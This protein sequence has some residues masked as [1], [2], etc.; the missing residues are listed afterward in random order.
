MT[1][2]L[3]S[4]TGLVTTKK[5]KPAEKVDVKVF[6]DTYEA[7]LTLWGCVAASAAAWKPS[8]TILFISNPGATVEGRVWLNLRQ[9]TQ[10]EVDPCI[11]DA[12]WLRGYAHR[13]VQKEHVNEPFPQGGEVYSTRDRRP[14]ADYTTIVFD[15]EAF[16]EAQTRLLFTL[17]EVDEL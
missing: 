3:L 2:T 5:G 16:A 12:E 9:S 14:R 7:T 17:A 15:V 6:D 1:W 11:E 4:R 13:L 8:H 10:V